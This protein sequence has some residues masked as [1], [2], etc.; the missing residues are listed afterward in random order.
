MS[1]DPYAPAPELVALAERWPTYLGASERTYKVVDSLGGLA[2]VGPVEVAVLRCS[3]CHD[4]IYPADL[5]GRVGH[6]TR[7]H[8]YRMDGRAFTGDNQ[9]NGKAPGV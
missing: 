7:H 9:P 6:L 5:P 4:E 3:S 2:D 8:G 1:A